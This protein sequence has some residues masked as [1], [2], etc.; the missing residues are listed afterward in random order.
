M[1]DLTERKYLISCDSLA[2]K[3]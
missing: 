1:Y 2:L 3:P